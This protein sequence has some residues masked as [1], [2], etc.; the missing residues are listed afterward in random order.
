MSKKT[1]QLLDQKIQEMLRKMAISLKKLEDQF[2]S[3]LFLVRKKY[4][5][6]FLVINL[7]ELS[8]LIC[9]FRYG[10]SLPVKRNASA[11]RLNVQNRFKKHIFC[12][13]NSKKLPEI[14]ESSFERKSLCLS[15]GSVFSSINIYKI[16]KN[17]N[18]SL[19]KTLYQDH[20]L[21]RQ[22]AFVGSHPKGAFDSSGYP[23]IL[24]TEF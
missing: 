7:K 14:C 23:K 21:L 1:R 13:T 9:L 4:K 8:N 15:F 11:K 16:N 18:F 2:L 19:E 17:T 10:R 20:N 12:S 6:M 3:T 24:T 22:Y 5:E